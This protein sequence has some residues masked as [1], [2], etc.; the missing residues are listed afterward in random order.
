MTK[1]LVFIAEGFEEIE[2]LTV[3]DVLRRANIQCDMCSITSNKEIKGTH[4]ILVNVDK[5]LEEIKS[6]EYNA[7]VIPGG[8]PGAT[9]LRDNNKL[10]DLIKEFNKDKKLIAAICAGPIVLSKANIIKG[11]EV[12]SYPGFEEDLKEGL[13]KEDL[14]VQ[15]GNIIT[16]RGPSAAMY[17]AFKILENLKKDSVK[18]IKEDMLLH[19]L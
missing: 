17:F 3:V 2:A 14:V 5:T 7:L 4:N 6:N 16:S 10:I 1:I 9:N 12:T 18:E 8:M 11:K 13:Y 15:D 19:L